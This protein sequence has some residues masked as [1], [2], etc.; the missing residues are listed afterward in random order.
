TTGL[1]AGGQGMPDIMNVGS[2]Y[3]GG[4]MDKF[5]DAFADLFDY[6]ADDL[7]DD[8][9]SGVINCATRDGKMYGLPFEV[10]T[11]ALVY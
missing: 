3:I 6:G 8:F 11:G 10:N 5:P 1:A 7:K 4:Y 2:D 9:P